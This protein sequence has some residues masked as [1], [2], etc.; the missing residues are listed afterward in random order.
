MPGRRPCENAAEKP[1]TEVLDTKVL[2]AYPEAAKPGG[3]VPR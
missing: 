3:G 1:G 2:M